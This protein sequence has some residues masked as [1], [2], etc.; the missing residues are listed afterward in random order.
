MTK[1]EFEVAAIADAVKKAARIAPTKGNAFDKAAGLLFDID[2]EV[3]LTVALKSTDLN[4]F[5]IEWVDPIEIEGDATRWRVPSAIFAQAISGLQIGSGRTLILE[6]KLTGNNMALHLTCGRLKAKFNL[7]DASFY[8]DWPIFDPASLITLNDLGGRISQVEW[9][10]DK[11]MPPLSGIHFDG[12]KIVSTDRYRLASAPM[13]VPNLSEAVTVPAGLLGQILRQTGE[14]Q[15]GLDDHHMLLMPDEHTQLRAILYGEEYPQV[16]RVMRR[17][18]PA[19][20]KARKT[21][22]LEVISRASAFSGSE[23]FPLLKV[24]IGREEFAVMMENLEVGLLGDVVEIP[25]YANHSRV[26]IFFSPT[27]L[28]EG[29]NACPSD[30]IEF[31]YDPDN[32]KALIRISGGSGYEC[33]LAPRRKDKAD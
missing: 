23:R 24:F 3:D 20:F 26:Q 16:E 13:E 2:P 25:G 32:P 30:E 1:I 10:A 15:F 14:V 4:I 11:S 18:Q 31:F 22:M 28:T 6:E 9:A 33:W 27:N 12:K 8:P 7:M 29:I 17:D 21:A 19:S 5:S